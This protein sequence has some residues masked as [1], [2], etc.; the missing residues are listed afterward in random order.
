MQAA[1]MIYSIGLCEYHRR[2]AVTET[3]E[4]CAS[5]L[6]VWWPYGLAFE[7]GAMVVTHVA[8][9]TNF[10]QHP[11]HQSIERHAKSLIIIAIVVNSK[12]T[13]PHIKIHAV[14]V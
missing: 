6:S 13:S 1:R 7:F 8:S 5:H 11:H 3:A 12:Q 2:R 4:R 9:S 10:T 14:S